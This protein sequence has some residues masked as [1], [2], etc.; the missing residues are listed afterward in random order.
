M[1]FERYLFVDQVRLVLFLSMLVVGTTLQIALLCLSYIL[2]N[3]SVI[4]KRVIYLSWIASV[5]C[6]IHFVVVMLI[7][8]VSHLITIPCWIYVLAAGIN[9]P[10]MA[11]PIFSHGLILNHRYRLHD[12]KRMLYVNKIDTHPSWIHQIWVNPKI[13]DTRVQ[14]LYVSLSITL[15][16]GMTAI[17]EFFGELSSPYVVGDHCLDRVYYLII[18]EGVVACF[19]VLSLVFVSWDVDD[20]IQLKDEF[21]MLFIFITPLFITYTIIKSLDVP[22]EITFLVSGCVNLIAVFIIV[23]YPIFLVYYPRHKEWD[24]KSS[25]L[26]ESRSE[27]ELLTVEIVVKNTLRYGEFEE[28]CVKAWVVELLYFIIDGPHLSDVQKNG[29]LHTARSSKIS[30]R[31]RQ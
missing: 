22:V 15:C 14:V 16:L 28:Y 4:R 26:Y 13:F 8:A 12:M 31:H 18:S 25:D 21:R 17:L 7:P 24:D 2:R 6:L 20:V 30:E 1:T 27:N 23:G 5:V 29:H 11:I 3:R 10:G 9:I 19:L